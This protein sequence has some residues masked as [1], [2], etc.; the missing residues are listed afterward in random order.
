MLIYTNLG[1]DAQTEFSK[2]WGIGY[3]LDNVRYTC[4]SA[5]ARRPEPPLRQLRHV[6]A[7]TQASEWQDVIKTAVQAALV[8]VILDLL[9]ITRCAPAT[10]TPA[11]RGGRTGRSPARS[12]RD[13]P[14]LEEHIDF[15]SVQALLFNGAARNWWQQTRLLVRYQSRMVD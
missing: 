15:V 7:R 14:W 10:R 2:T 9:R 13:R 4:C 8:L 5:S 12:R 1:S 3:A 11:H 6:T